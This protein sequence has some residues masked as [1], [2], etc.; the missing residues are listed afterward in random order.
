MFSSKSGKSDNGIGAFLG[1]ESV[2]T[3]RLEFEGSVRVDGRFTG[4][5]SGGVLLVGESARIEGKIVVEELQSAGAVSGEVLAGR[6]VSLSRTSAFSGTLRTPALSV[7]EGAVLKG[8][9]D[10][11]S[12]QAALGSETAEPEL[13]PEG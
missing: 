8:E 13:L 12:P 2:Y 11:L 1:P 4:E 5:I 10:M 3:G 6:R 7:E 9:V